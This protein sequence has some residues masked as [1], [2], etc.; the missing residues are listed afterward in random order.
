MGRVKKVSK[1]NIFLER[2]RVQNSEKSIIVDCSACGL[3]S[4]PEKKI[5]SENAITLQ[6]IMM[7]QQVFSASIIAK[8][9]SLG[10]GVSEKNALVSPVAHPEV[11]DDL[12]ACLFQ[13]FKN[14]DQVNRKFPVWMRMARLNG[15]AHQS[16]F[17][18]LADGVEALKQIRK[19]NL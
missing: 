10:L 14:V 9:E 5:F 18:Y 19:A 3:A 1:N 16:L 11:V 12:P 15:A 6:S 17:S 4:R 7:C 8:I 13:S 2:G